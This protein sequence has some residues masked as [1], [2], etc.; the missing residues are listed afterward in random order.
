M[1]AV[2]T[3]RIYVAVPEIYARVAEAGAKT[4]VTFDEFPGETFSG[5]VVRNARA[6]DGDVIVP[7]ETCGI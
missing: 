6:I 5:T 2:K 4:G 7:T 3:L 1:A